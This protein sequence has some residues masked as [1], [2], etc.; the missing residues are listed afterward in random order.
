MDDE[1]GDARPPARSRAGTMIRVLAVVAM[2]VA[3]PTSCLGG[4]G[5][6]WIRDLPD[7]PKSLL[8]G[9]VEI[10][11]CQRGD[12]SVEVELAVN[13][14]FERPVDYVLDVSI[15][16]ADSG[17]VLGHE[18]ERPYLSPGEA[19]LFTS[20]VPVDIE[21]GVAVDCTVDVGE[22]CLLTCGSLD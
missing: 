19:S 3:I 21:P 8:A 5:Y 2:I 12:G 4:L 10:R 15:R 1:S 16:D 11:S 6:L 17:D 20:S 13:N 9:S 7:F 14:R 18:L 22:S